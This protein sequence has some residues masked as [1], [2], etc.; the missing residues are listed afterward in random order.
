MPPNKK[1]K[2]NYTRTGSVQLLHTDGVPADVPG[3]GDATTRGCTVNT[4]RTG[5][6]LLAIV[7]IWGSAVLLLVLLPP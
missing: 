7:L 1:R 3:A 4:V 5:L 6:L 2:I